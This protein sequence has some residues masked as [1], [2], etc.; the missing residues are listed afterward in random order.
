MH[1]QYVLYEWLVARLR[2][3]RRPAAAAAGKVPHIGPGDIFVMS[4]LAKIGATLVTYPLLVVKSR[5]Q[6]RARA[7][8]G[9]LLVLVF[10]VV[11]L[12][13][14]EGLVV[15]SAWQPPSTNPTPLFI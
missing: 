11:G 1:G 6:V 10:R 14:V 4:S 7:R 5:L 15:L 3:L 8:G 12:F 9:C 2:T 13:G